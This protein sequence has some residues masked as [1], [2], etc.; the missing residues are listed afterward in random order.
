[1]LFFATI[2][3]SVPSEL[4][5]VNDNLQ[6]LFDLFQPR[7]LRL[8]SAKQEKSSGGG[9]GGGGIR[10]SVLKA[11]LTRAS[12]HKTHKHYPT[13]RWLWGFVAAN[14]GAA[15]AHC[16][17]RHWHAPP[18]AIIHDD[19]IQVLAVHVLPSKLRLLSFLNKA[20]E[21]DSKYN[22]SCRVGS[23][24]SCRVMSCRVVSCVCV[25][26]CLCAILCLG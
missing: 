8:L 20:L 11:D 4:A 5:R 2:L 14:E 3:F 22:G 19:T 12:L 7:F 9:G 6:H 24:V 25:C 10:Q 15:R 18:S 23:C 13:L 1:V 21:Y 16:R 26:V 17:R